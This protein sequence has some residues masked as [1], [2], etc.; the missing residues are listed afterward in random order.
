MISLFFAT[1]LKICKR[2]SAGNSIH[3]DMRKKKKS[4][5]CQR[6]HH[7]ASFYTPNNENRVTSNW[8]K[9][10]VIQGFF[11]LLQRYLLYKKKKKT[12]FIYS[13]FRCRNALFNF[14]CLNFFGSDRSMMTFSQVLIK[15]LV[16][17]F[18]THECFM[19]KKKKE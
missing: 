3:F 1:I 17:F 13:V 12:L 18:F 6:T 7:Y 2:I 5:L 9:K 11:F 15:V 4:I 10:I 8:N 14:I 16:T 19:K